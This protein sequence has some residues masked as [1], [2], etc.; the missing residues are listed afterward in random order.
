MKWPIWSWSG[1]IGSHSTGSV[2]M[3]HRYYKPKRLRKLD[4]SLVFPCAPQC[5]LGK[6]P[7]NSAIETGSTPVSNTFQ[8]LSCMWVCSIL[9][10]GITAAGPASAAQLPEDE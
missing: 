9:S 1:S 7:Y 6:S 8:G 10:L 4:L 5:T 3:V 2:V